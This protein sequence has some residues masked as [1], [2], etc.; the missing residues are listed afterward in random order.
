MN[1]RHI[2]L[3]VTVTI[4]VPAL[5]AAQARGADHPAGGQPAQR[6]QQ[7]A[8]RPV[9]R[10]RPAAHPEEQPVGGGY[11]PPHGP[12]TGRARPATVP[13]A[14]GRGGRTFGDRANHPDAPHVHRDN[15]WIG[16]NSGRNDIHYHLDHPWEHGRFIG[17]I[18][19]RFVWRLH[20]GGVD[21]FQI[22]GFFFQ[23]APYDYDYCSDW[24]WDS[25]DIVLYDD[26]DHL[27]WYVAYNVRLG[28][29][30][31]VMYLGG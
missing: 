6:G 13:A 21:R 15:I 2:V 16:H 8:Q 30:C 24:L 4:L 27:G 18:G 3:A 22:G 29:D 9:Q 20:G 7:R 23:V 1:M 5:A 10:P 17:G 25:D 26:P 31:H 19:P 11:V 12:P 28:T 14:T